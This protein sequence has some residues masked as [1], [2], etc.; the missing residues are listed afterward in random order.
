MLTNRKL[1]ERG[2]KDKNFFICGMLN[3]EYTFFSFHIQERSRKL[4]RFGIKSL[5]TTLKGLSNEN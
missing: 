4:Y 5:R 2:N 3:L 1:R